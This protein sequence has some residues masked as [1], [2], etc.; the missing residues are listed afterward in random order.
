MKIPS[1]KVWLVTAFLLLSVFIYSLG[2][3]FPDERLWA[4]NHL[5]YVPSAVRWFWIG[6]GFTFFILL[7]MFASLAVFSRRRSA[8][9][10]LSLSHIL[11]TKYGIFLLAV[12]GLVSFV[13]GSVASYFLGDGHMIVN[14]LQYF[15]AHPTLQINTEFYIRHP[16]T[17]LFYIVS[18]YG[19]SLVSDL[20][21]GLFL[22]LLSYLAGFVFLVVVLRFLRA[23]AS[24]DTDIGMGISLMVLNGAF[25]LFF[26]YVEN[27]V[28]AYVMVVAYLVL[29]IRYLSGQAR[30]VSVVVSFSLAIAFHLSS[31]LLLPSLLYLV[32]LRLQ[33]RRARPIVSPLRIWILVVI[34]LLGLSLFYVLNGSFKTFDHLLHTVSGP[35]LSQYT[36]FSAFHL[37]DMVNEIALVSPLLPLS[38]AVILLYGGWKARDLT[39]EKRTFLYL[40]AVYGLVFLFMAN[41]ELGLAR[42]WDAFA[43]VGITLNCA[44]L[45][46]V[47]SLAI[48][49][50]EKR[51]IAAAFLGFGVWII[52]PWLYVN[53][54]VRASVERYEK[55]LAL[56]ADLIRPKD[57]AYGYEG[58][59]AYYRNRGES[60]R[61]LHMLDRMSDYHKRARYFIVMRNLV[62]GLDKSLVGDSIIPKNLRKMR[63]YSRKVQ[64]NRLTQ[65]DSLF[66]LAFC[67]VTAYWANR[68]HVA[69]AH[70]YAN[71]LEG[72]FP[73]VPRV[74]V[75][76]AEMSFLGG[77][78]QKAADHF[79][80]AVDLDSAR[81]HNNPELAAT[82][83]LSHR[84]AGNPLRSAE[85]YERA[86][87][88]H[89]RAYKLYVTLGSIYSHD[90]DDPKRGME[91]WEKLV[92]LAP[93]TPEGQK[94]QKELSRIRGR[95]RRTDR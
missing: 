18:V 21:I 56:D 14:S 59:E 74:Q 66:L 75:L 7:G 76:V 29:S 22:R 54:D 13:S 67:D 94:A 5:S 20:D 69:D 61:Q 6:V 58:L 95:G 16:L 24:G 79:E 86:L 40:A 51:F 30:L 35:G 90:L 31:A 19:I 45:M 53:A 62:F 71:E 72:R 80:S 44:A 68:G 28:F 3:F 39:P 46:I 12:V 63:E 78:Y 1:P 15:I 64:P 37:V 11:A 52:V 87:Q 26:G 25:L 73:R 32:L 81:V 49:E 60:L 8:I 4:F 43:V 23:W 93:E 2:S 57:A 50:T 84:Y 42:D 85:I 55:I 92:Q 9:S 65:R 48:P 82:W 38:I 33:S 47:A 27:Y 34:S 36:L 77:D 10:H 91:V 70:N 41:P 88:L 83:G 89:P 17:S